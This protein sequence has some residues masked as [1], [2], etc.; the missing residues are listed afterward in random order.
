MATLLYNPKAFADD[1]ARVIR[2]SKSS[3]AIRSCLLTTRDRD[4]ALSMLKETCT[5][6]ERP[7]FHFTISGRRRYNPTQIKWEIVGGESQDVAG[8]LRQTQELRG[9]GVVAL[10][11]CAAFLRDDGGD[12]RM[13][14]LLADMMSAE[15]AS[16]GL[17]LVFIEPPEGER[18]LP[19][20]LAD[21]FVR[22][23]VPYPR[24]DELEA[25][26][27]E[28]IAVTAHRTRVQME[29]NVIRREAQRLAPGA[30]GLTRSAA[31]D[32]VR[33]ALAPN[34]NDFDAAFER[35]QTRKAMQLR[36]ELAMNILDTHAVE[37]PIGLD[38]LVEHLQVEKDKILTT[39]ADRARGILLIGPPGTGKT[40]LARAIGRLVDLPVVEFKLS[41]L[42]NS[43]LGE[44][45]RRFSQAFAT[46]EAMSPNVVFMDEI[47]KAFGDSSERDGGTMMRCTGAL[48]SWL[49][50]NPYPNF[51]VG[52]CNSLTRMGEIGLTMTRSERFDAAFFVDVP[53]RDSR[54]RMLERWLAGLTDESSSVSAELADLSEKFSGADLRSVVKRALARA[55]KERTT[56]SVDHLKSQIERKRMRAIALYDEF[57]ELR[58]WGRKYCDPAGPTDN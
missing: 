31:R 38:Y 41:S 25:I 55:R 43:L 33:D 23:D 27:R 54:A 50:D 13:R 36:R 30:I 21:Q 24:A 17:V 4:Y 15:T 6:C 56:L 39:G 8:L 40:M 45:E 52:T 51:I 46:L 10:E 9:G 11:D 44:T 48:L 28:E 1:L 37:E 7:L 49:S 29:V 5:V 2:S 14:M 20:I 16:D 57:Q 19:S 34:P 18:Q 26:A 22:L 53:S 42:M 58:R 12:P 35:L 32:A 3:H 47:E